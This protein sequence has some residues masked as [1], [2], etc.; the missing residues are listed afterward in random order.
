M[1]PTTVEAHGLILPRRFASQTAV[2]AYVAELDD[3]QFTSFCKV[4]RDRRWT[5]AEMEERIYPLRP[6]LDPEDLP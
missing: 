1:N 4:L 2:A 3:E 6:D 5:D